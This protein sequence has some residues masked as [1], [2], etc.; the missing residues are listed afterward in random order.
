[1]GNKQGQ[2]ENE[3]RQAKEQTKAQSR[4]SATSTSVAV[5]ENSKESVNDDT[6]EPV[7]NVPT[8]EEPEIIK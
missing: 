5:V 2:P 6:G 3:K 7:E 4:V 1:M 8:E